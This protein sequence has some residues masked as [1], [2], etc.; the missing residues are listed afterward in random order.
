MPQILKLFLPLKVLELTNLFNSIQKIL[1]LL[2]GMQEVSYQ[3]DKNKELQLE[4]LL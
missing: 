3:E 4:E 1:I 2:W